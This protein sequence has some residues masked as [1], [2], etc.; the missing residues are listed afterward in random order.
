MGEVGRPCQYQA[1]REYDMIRHLTFAAA[2]FAS[3]AGFAAPE[4]A[5]E[6][7]AHLSASASDFIGDNVPAELKAQYAELSEEDQAAVRDR[8]RSGATDR[9]EERARETRASHRRGRVADEARAH[10]WSNRPESLIGQG[11]HVDPMKRSAMK[12]RARGYSADRV[13]AHR[14]R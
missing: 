8:F 5:P 3:T 1:T 13:S 14:S 4:R 9:A 2:L 10:A 11:E 12:E 6:A 7:K